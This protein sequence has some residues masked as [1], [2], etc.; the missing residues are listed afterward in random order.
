MNVKLYKGSQWREYRF[1]PDGGS[2]VLIIRPQS[3]CKSE[4]GRKHDGWSVDECV[5]MHT[6]QSAPLPLRLRWRSFSTLRQLR[7]YFGVW[8]A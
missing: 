8:F 2:I 5:N 7:M 4:Y 1:S 3:M 6:G